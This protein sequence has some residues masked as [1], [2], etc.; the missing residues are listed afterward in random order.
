MAI[1]D[2]SE[3]KNKSI[4]FLSNTS[5]DQTQGNLETDEG[6]SDV[7]VLIGRQFNNIL[8]R[9]DRRRRPNVKNISSDIGK[10]SDS[11]IK[12]KA[13]EQPNQG[14]ALQCYGCD[15]FANPT[16]RKAILFPSL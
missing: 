6:I 1:I 15:G 2:K 8:K 9:M 12:T 11:Q 10:N 16:N 7:M 5:D 3:K 14:K 13:K 4:V